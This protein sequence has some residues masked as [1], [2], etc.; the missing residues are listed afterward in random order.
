MY[1]H[2][3]VSLLLNR[4]EDIFLCILMQ[5]MAG[6]LPVLSFMY[7]HHVWKKHLEYINNQLKLTSFLVKGLILYQSQI[8]SKVNSK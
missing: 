2:P 5:Y 7:D 3:K 1:L 4:V 6:K 8:L